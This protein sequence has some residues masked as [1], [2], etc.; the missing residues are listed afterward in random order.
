MPS[1]RPTP[2]LRFWIASASKPI[3]SSAL[4]HP[5]ADGRLELERPVAHYIPEF[6]AHGKQAVTVEQVMLMTAGFPEAPMSSLDGADATRRLARLADWKLDWEPGSRYVYH[7]MS[8]H[9]VL[10]ELLERVTDVPGE[11]FRDCVER[12]VTRPLGLPRLFGIPRSELGDVAQLSAAADETTRS[13]YAYEA[14]IEA[15]EP[16]GG[17]VAR[18]T[19]LALFYQGLLHNRCP[20]SAC[21]RDE[22]VFPQAALEDALRN[23]RTACPTR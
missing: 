20:G 4:L 12:T 22:P 15:G 9:W 23:V 7:P 5:I 10:A 18:A 13:A 17:A 11:D 21:D 19:D 14:K 8:A 16:G 1:A 2:D 6:G 3:F